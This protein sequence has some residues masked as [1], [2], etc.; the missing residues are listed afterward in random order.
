[1]LRG[2]LARP[3]GLPGQI[4]TPRSPRAPHSSL[5]CAQPWPKKEALTCRSEQVTVQDPDYG[6]VTQTR[7]V[8]KLKPGFSWPEHALREGFR[9]RRLALWWPSG[10]R[11]S[12][13]PLSGIDELVVQV[14]AKGG[15][16]REGEMDVWGMAQRRAAER[17][18]S[19][20]HR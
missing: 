5:T 19:Q 8:M 3:T 9:W 20:R 6:P 1:M 2:L 13:L 7:F 17:P 12:G 15:V 18:A 16:G 14:R 10:V 11:L 4:K